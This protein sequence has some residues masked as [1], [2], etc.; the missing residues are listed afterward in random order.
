MDPVYLNLRD[1]Y[2]YEIWVLEKV[3]Q[4]EVGLEGGSLAVQGDS[5]AIGDVVALYSCLKRADIIY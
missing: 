2:S 5:A 3:V 1:L 4:M